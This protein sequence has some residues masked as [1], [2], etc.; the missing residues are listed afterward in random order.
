MGEVRVGNIRR[1]TMI[2]SG[3]RTDERWTTGRL[4]EG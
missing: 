3:E 1:K 2:K 4:E